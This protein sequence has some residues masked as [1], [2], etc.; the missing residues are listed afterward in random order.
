MFDECQYPRVTIEVWGNLRCNCLRTKRRNKRPIADSTETRVY[1][2]LLL[3][4][5][6]NTSTVLP[7]RPGGIYLFRNGT[8]AEMSTAQSKSPVCAHP[9]CESDRWKTIMHTGSTVSSFSPIRSFSRSIPFCKKNCLSFVFCMF[10]VNK[11][12][13]KH[14][15]ILCS[16]C[17]SDQ[18]VQ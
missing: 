17:N 2:S 11:I 15:F 4:I 10:P 13:C 7:D 14:D 16:R 5:E 8:N 1:V 12:I 9:K 6:L 3:P 18:V